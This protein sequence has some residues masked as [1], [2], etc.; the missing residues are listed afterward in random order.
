MIKRQNIDNNI[1]FNN[2][3]QKLQHFL[4]F[5]QD[6][7]FLTC[8]TRYRIYWYF[9]WN[10]CLS[11]FIFAT[12]PIDVSEG[13]EGVI[14]ADSANRVKS[15]TSNIVLKSLLQRWVFGIRPCPWSE[16][17]AVFPLICFFLCYGGSS[18]LLKRA[19]WEVLYVTYCFVLWC[20]FSC[21]GLR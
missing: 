19:D 11:L 2:F 20:W 21:L 18:S 16:P 10:L 8:Q 13:L 4:P 17:L 3:E 7:I 6:S 15:R 9:G 1:N 5:Y 12:S 14:P